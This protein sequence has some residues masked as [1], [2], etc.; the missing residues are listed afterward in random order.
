MDVA[1]DVDADNR[2]T[3]TAS[4]HDVSGTRRFKGGGRRYMVPP[5]TITEAPPGPQ[6]DGQQK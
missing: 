1:M 3:S 6:P 4:G 2:I 5:D